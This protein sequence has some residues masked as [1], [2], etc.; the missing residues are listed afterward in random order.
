HA[1]DFSSASF[2]HSA[3]FSGASFGYRADFSGASFGNHTDFSGASFGGSANFSGASFGGSADFSGASFGG[4]AG[5]SDTRFGRFAYFSDAN[6]EGSVFFKGTDRDQQET[7]LT[8]LAK[9]QIEEEGERETWIKAQLEDGYLNKLTSISFCRTRFGGKTDFK[10]RIFEDFANFSH[11]KFDQP[12]RFENCEGM[13]RLDVTGAQFS[14]TG[15]RP[16]YWPWMSE[17]KN[18][19][20]WTTDSNIPTQLRILRKQMEDIKA[21]DAERDLFIAERQAERGVLISESPDAPGTFGVL[22]LFYLYQKLSD[23]GRSARLPAVWL[24]WKSYAFFLGYLLLAQFGCI[25]WEKQ[26]ATLGD[27]VADIFSFTLGHAL[28]FLSSLSKVQED[29]LTKLFGSGPQGQIDM[30]LIMQFASTIQSLIGALL[31]FLFLQAIRNHF[32]L[33]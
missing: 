6:F 3:N 25:K 15:E 13:E 1:A 32:R 30:P 7:R 8:E 26:K 5:F 20:G 23:C 10:D 11:A 9:Q 4:I 24:L 16:K 28:P 22:L 21:H 12:P 14:F 29:L 33:R 31:L 2:G 18:Q 19:R 17:A 27:F